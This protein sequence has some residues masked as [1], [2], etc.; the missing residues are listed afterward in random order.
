MSTPRDDRRRQLEELLREPPQRLTPPDGAWDHISR[1]AR[2]R[3][4]AK[5]VIGVAAGVIITAGAVPAVIAVRHAGGADQT[6]AA[7]GGFTPG[8]H[9]GGSTAPSPLAAP[10]S[11]LAG[12][13]PESVSFRSLTDGYLWGSIAGS[14]TGVIATTT[15]GGASWARSPAPLV[16]DSYV[17]RHGDGQVRFATD[18]TGF[19]FGS[20]Y[21]VSHDS[22][23][24]W[25]ELS[26]PGYIDTLE[27][28]EGRVW[29][30]VRAH[31]RSQVVSLYSATTADPRLRRVADV[32]PMRGP[33]GTATTAGTDSLAVSDYSV[34]VIVG[35]AGFWHSPHGTSWSQGVDPCQDGPGKDNPVQS[36]VVSISDAGNVVA[37][38]GYRFAAN[39]REGKQIYASH[40][41]GRSWHRTATQ[42]S[43]AGWLQTLASGT[44]TS[45]I[46]GTTR[47]GAQITHDAGARWTPVTA[48][49]LKLSF[50]GYISGSQIVALADRDSEQGAFAASTN[51]GETW[52]VFRF[53]P[54]P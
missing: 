48:D 4:T 21:F 5:A 8:Q 49:G 43:S 46:L 34:V 18:G 47:G 29:A 27:T 9:T 15:N 36:A 19:V 17:S 26:S 50:V 22:G 11:D 38:C 37:G 53:P 31:P 25:S 16:N 12:F 6:V 35:S 2:R 14:N 33:A 39:N 30:L 45:T 44:P 3:K 42:P 51:S 13:V 28:R 20:R 23:Q 32:P 10:I 1:R 24:T 40:N 7:G 54:L 52:T 41:S